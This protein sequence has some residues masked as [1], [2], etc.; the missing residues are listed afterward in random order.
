MSPRSEP[1]RLCEA[2]WHVDVA[3]DCDVTRRH[4]SEPVRRP[5]RHRYLVGAFELA[6][7]TAGH[8]GGLLIDLA[9]A[10]DRIGD[11]LHDPGARQ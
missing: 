7:R 1:G 2:R 8:A 4:A 6:S 9:G 5:P 11:A 3:R 10:L